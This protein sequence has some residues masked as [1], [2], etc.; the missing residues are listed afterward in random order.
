MNPHQVRI[1]A[2]VLVGALILAAAAT[3]ISS[4]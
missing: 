1:V 4:L 3:I 2:L